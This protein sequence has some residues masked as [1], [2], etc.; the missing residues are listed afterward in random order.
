MI[1]GVPETPGEDEYRGPD[2]NARELAGS[3]DQ[4]DSAQDG[5]SQGNG[6]GADSADQVDEAPVEIRPSFLAPVGASSG[7]TEHGSYGTAAYDMSENAGPAAAL[8]IPPEISSRE[9]GPLVAATA[10]AAQTPVAAE[11]SALET[12]PSLNRL[13]LA[14]V[15]DERDASDDDSSSDASE[16]PVRQRREINEDD[17]R[18]IDSRVSSF[19]GRYHRGGGLT[20]SEPI[21]ERRLGGVLPFI[22]MLGFDVFDRTEVKVVSESRY[23]VGTADDKFIVSLDQ[24]GGLPDD[25][26]LSTNGRRFDLK[27]QGDD[28]ATT[29]A[30]LEISQDTSALPGLF[31]ALSKEGFD[32][33]HLRDMASRGAI[34][35][36]L[37]DAI[38]EEL[39]EPSSLLRQ[40][41]SARLHARGYDDSALAGLATIGQNIAADA[42]T[43]ENETEN[44]EEESDR[45]PMKADE[46]R[47]FEAVRELLGAYVDAKRVIAR[48]GVQ[49]TAILLDDNNR[50]SIARL[51]Y[52]ASS[53]KY[54]A[55]LTG[56]ADKNKVDETKHLISSP[57]DIGKFADK[58][59]ARLK[60]VEPSAVP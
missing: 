26:I 35:D 2:W 11:V 34:E 20:G 39:R 17:N 31:R 1:D 9:D 45:R 30:L 56:R 55:T 40:A 46:A 12:A 53:N 13:G 50:R 36:V 57:D 54:L 32:L 24:A 37:R 58:I 51:Y 8:S 22:G 33:S 4:G 25:I 21:E 44:A 41:I 10:I 5:P 15:D 43:G 3:D 59:V 23:L 7:E 28:S 49:Y 42:L 19:F 48:P 14:P 27:I 18:A 52:N 16:A 38:L 6:A 47:A 29:I 60:E